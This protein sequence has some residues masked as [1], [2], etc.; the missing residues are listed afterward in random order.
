M[1]TFITATLDN[2]LLS[3]YMRQQMDEQFRRIVDGDYELVDYS[4]G[5]SIRLWINDEASDYN[6]HWHTAVEM[7]MVL[8][9]DYRVIMNKE[10]Y[11][12]EP[13]DIMVIPAGELHH[14]IAPPTGIRLIYLFD[15]TPLS[16]IKGFSYL[17]TYLSHPILISA[18][19]PIALY[20]TLAQL[21]LQMCKDYYSGDTMRELLVY[22]RVL[23][24]FAHYGKYQMTEKG[25]ESPLGESPLK[26]KELLE[27]LNKAFEYL[28][29]HFT[30]NLTL[31]KVAST[32]GFSKFHF[33][34]MFKQCSGHNFYD[35]LCYRRIK[36]AESLLLNP[37]LSITEIALQSGFS[38]LSTF[39]RTFK[40]TK[41]CTPSEY[42]NLYSNAFTIH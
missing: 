15:F 18:K 16:K 41:N 40:R 9:N 30:E 12:L 29:S 3:S 17:N 37:S 2:E 28:D 20:Q 27:K 14:L 7:I 25:N 13:G 21:I 36:S 19:A 24:F 10:E 42:R 33:S 6:L 1:D 38:S 32:A 26:H 23:E 5:S 11:H 39:N 34:R 35:Y 22:S 31:E 4:P 8:E